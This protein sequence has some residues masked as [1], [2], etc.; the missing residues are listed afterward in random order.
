MVDERSREAREKLELYLEYF[1]STPDDVQT[2]IY[3]LLRVDFEVENSP[4]LGILLTKMENHENSLLYPLIEVLFSFENFKNYANDESLRDSQMLQHLF[5]VMGRYI[6]PCLSE[7]KSIRFDPWPW[8]EYFLNDSSRDE[9][10]GLFIDDTIFFRNKFS[11]PIAALL[12]ASLY[13]DLDTGRQKFSHY[14]NLFNAEY[15]RSR[16]AHQ[17]E[18]IIKGRLDGHSLTEIIDWWD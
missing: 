16:R 12:Y 8:L 6:V 9:K 2:Q 5:D 17:C 4:Y 3:S 7:T 10:L 15:G 11:T 1:S 18:M 13:C 14:I